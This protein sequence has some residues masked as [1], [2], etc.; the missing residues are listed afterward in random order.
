[1]YKIYDEWPKIA[2]ESFNSDQEIVNFN[3]I[4][5]IV[6]AGMGGSGTIGDV[7]AAVLSKSKIHVN[8]VK[9]YVLP[10]T[11]NSKTLVIT[12]SVSGDTMETLS[13]LKAAKEKKCR[14]IAFSSDG[15]MLEFCVKNNIQ[16]RNVKQFHSPRASFT[17]YLYT[18]LKVL[19]QTLG[20]NQNDIFES[21]NELYNNSKKINSS[22]L[23]DKNPSLM[24]AK[25]ITGIPI[26][27]YPF[28]L[29]SACIRF[30]NSL[31][32]NAKMHVMVEDVIEMCHNGIVGWE[33]R[34]K[35]QPILVR[36][37]DDQIMTKKRWE[38]LKKYF[39]KNEIEYK[40]IISTD[41][42]I[43]SKI[44]NLIYFLDYCSIYKAVLEQINPTTINSIKY[45]KSELD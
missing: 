31:N 20:I 21:I 3:D 5:H 9:G 30:K 41:G 34:A 35:V 18:I 32:E 44:I 15:K 25:W 45:I 39:L 6:F 40:E 4:E 13:I 36:G 24:L 11:A 29:K 38:I 1:M 37:K 28:G 16:H 7:F 19:Y 14:I 43:L 27:Y 8:V 42:S 23:T 26:I 10:E 17:S 2:K 33:T 22:N 12:V